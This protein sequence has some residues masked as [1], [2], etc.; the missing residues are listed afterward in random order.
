VDAQAL[1]VR[2]TLDQDR[3]AV[4]QA[5]MTDPQIQARLGLDETWQLVDELI[6]AEAEW[7]P[8]WLRG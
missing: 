1:T 6:E 5:A 8:D 4:Y 7:L 2:A 3:S